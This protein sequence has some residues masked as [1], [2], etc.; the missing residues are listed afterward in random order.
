MV[1][2]VDDLCWKLCDGTRK[3]RKMSWLAWNLIVKVAWEVWGG[4][5]FDLFLSF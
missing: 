5:V 1:L 3:V 2:E 4:E